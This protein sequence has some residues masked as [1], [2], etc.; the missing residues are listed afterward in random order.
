MN[1][2]DL[3]LKWKKCSNTCKATDM[4]KVWKIPTNNIFSTEENPVDRNE[5]S[6]IIKFITKLTQ[7][8]VL[9]P[10]PEVYN[11]HYVELRPEG[12]YLQHSSRSMSQ[13]IEKREWKQKYW[14]GIGR[15]KWCI[16]KWQTLQIISLKDFNDTYRK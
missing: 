13:I 14:S 5:N 6:S 7:N 12:F 10:L 15:Y 9:Q 4:L 1:R 8:E 16:S 2:W 11:Y 3:S